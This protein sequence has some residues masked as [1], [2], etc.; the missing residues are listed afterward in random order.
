M[1]DILDIVHLN[2]SGFVLESNLA[3]AFQQRILQAFHERPAR[4]DIII[5]DQLDQT[6]RRFIRPWSPCLNGGSTFAALM[7]FLWLAGSR[8]SWSS[9]FWVS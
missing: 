6:P 3:A 4:G 8:A 5:Y 2:V 9:S 7:M 1:I